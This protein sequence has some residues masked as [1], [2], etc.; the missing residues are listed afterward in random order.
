VRPA[1]DSGFRGLASEYG[2]PRCRTR[3]DIHDMAKRHSTTPI[4]TAEL[5]PDICQRAVHARDPRFDG[6][7]FVAITTTGV[8][9]RPVCPARVV[10]AERRRFFLSAAAAEHAGYRPCLRCRPELAPG[11][12]ICDAVSRLAGTAAHRIAAGALNGRSVAQL[13]RELCVSER[14]LRRALERE[15]GVTPV[16]LAQTH[17]LL[18]AKR[19]LADTDLSITRIAYAS[20]FQSLRRFNS[21]FR[22]RYRMPP[23]ALRR[24]PQAARA[25]RGNEESDMLRLTLSYRAP[26]AWDAL[27]AELGR[28]AVPGIELVARGQY[29]RTVRLN[30]ATGVVFAWDAAHERGARSSRRSA[31]SSHLNIAL[32][33]SLLPELMPLL[34]KLRHLFDLDAEPSVIDGHL[35]QGGLGDLIRRTPG[36]RIPGAF[37]GFE[38][39]LRLIVGMDAGDGAVQRGIAQHI[40]EQLGERIDSYHPALALLAPDAERVADAGA[41]RLAALGVTRRSAEAIVRIARAVAE[42]TLRLEPGADVAPTRE[43]LAETMGLGSDVASIISMRALRWPDAFPAADPALQRAI[44]VTSERALLE[45]AESWRPWRAYAAARLSGI[46]NIENSRPRVR[47][48]VA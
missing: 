30:G 8:Y 39:A 1:G 16:E 35:G 3:R 46:I 4:N 10:H 43:A 34:A 24:S 13:A 31:R 7:F 27:L 40:A 23:S 36:V 11:R 20:G 9:C 22:D 18:L 6:V 33:T 32:S 44:G 45:R 38:I 29:A 21:V 17:R 5:T 14:H 25:A 26:F 28:D 47:T 42:G 15:L 41:L 2:K 37:D 19:L 12:A 48:A